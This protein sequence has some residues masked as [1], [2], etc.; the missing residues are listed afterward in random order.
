[1][2]IQIT[3]IIFS[4]IRQVKK[5]LKKLPSNLSNRRIV[6]KRMSREGLLMAITLKVGG[7]KSDADENKDKMCPPPCKMRRAAQLFSN[8]K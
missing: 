5:Y 6:H 2:N 1:M 4:L 7:E 8:T 3:Q